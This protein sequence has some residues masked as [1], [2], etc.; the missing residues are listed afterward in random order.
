MG[1]IYPTQERSIDP[2]SSYNSDVFNKFTRIATGGN[3]G[4]LSSHAIEIVE[5]STSPHTYV[6][7]SP[8]ICFKD[9]VMISITESF[10]VNFNDA[11][12]YESGSTIFDE[13]GYYYILLEY[14]YAKSKPAPQASIHILKPSQRLSYDTTT[15]ILLKVVNVVFGGSSFQ[16]DELLDYDP[17]LPDNKIIFTPMSASLVH[18]IPDFDPDYDRGK[19]IY[20][21]YSDTGY[22]GTLDGWRSLA[23]LDYPCNAT[24]CSVGQL[25]YLDGSGYAHPALGTSATTFALG[26]IVKSGATGLIRLNGFVDSGL[27]EPGITLSGGD[28]LYLSITSSGRVTN[29]LPGSGAYQSIGKCF[30]TDGTSSFTTVLCSLGQTTDS[31][32]SHNLLGGIDGG[33]STYKYH[34]S[35]I[36]YNHVV[37][38]DFTHNNLSSKQGGDGTNFYHLSATQYNNLVSSIGNVPIGTIIAWFPT[39]FDSNTSSLVHVLNPTNNIVGA[40]AYLNPLGFWVC[41]GS[42]PNRSESPIWNASNKHVPTL[43]DNRFIQGV[44]T[45]PSTIYG[46]INTSSHYHTVATNNHTLITSE[47]PTHTHQAPTNNG[48]TPGIYEVGVG[49]AFLGTGW[50]GYDFGPQSAPTDGGTGGGGAHNHGTSNSSTP[51]GSGTENRPYYLTCFYIIRVF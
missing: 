42:A 27:I 10:R 13:S 51:V 2:F 28:S 19:I 17:E 26:F 40:N 18:G 32:P 1:E 44:S 20:D 9:D 30:S 7:I 38:Q 43:T 48:L 6:V 45:I 14:V 36:N 24:F 23:N 8:G 5:D 29:M 4:I 22:M 11:S 3:D 49:N 21:R 41:D 34:L 46:G 15:Y 39:Y 37:N 25:A 12:F 47:I 33:D 16:V 50:A 31:I 35:S